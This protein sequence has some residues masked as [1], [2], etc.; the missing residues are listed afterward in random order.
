MDGTLKAYPEMDL[1]PMPRKTSAS[2]LHICKGKTRLFVRTC[3]ACWDVR[4]K[5]MHLTV[6]RARFIGSAEIIYGQDIADL[7]FFNQTEKSYAVVP[8]DRGEIGTEEE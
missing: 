2:K 8:F 6:D 4:L 7:D 5:A 1:T 3:P